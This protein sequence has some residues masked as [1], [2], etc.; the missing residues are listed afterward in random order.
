MKNKIII[1]ATICITLFLTVF[2]VSSILNPKKPEQSKDKD[3]TSQSG[4]T[5]VVKASED[6][7]TPQS[8]TPKSNTNPKSDTKTSPETKT[9]TKPNVVTKK[10]SFAAVGDNLIHSS[11]YE[12]AKL[13]ASGT[14]ETYN[15]LPMYDNVKSMIQS[16][17]L[18]FVNQEG[19]TAGAKLV[20]SGYPLFNA[21]DEA[22]NTLVS[23]GFDI[24]N[25]AN[26]HM[27][28]KGETG[29]ANTIQFW[30]DKPVTTIGGYSSEA[31]YNKIRVIEKSGIKIALLSYTYG[32]NGMVLPTKSPYIIPLINKDE[33]DRQTKEARKLA[34]IVVVSIHWGVEDSF[35]PNDEQIALANLM[36]NN[37]V[38]VILG[39]HPHVL[40]PLEWKTRPDGGKTLVAYSLGNFLSTMLYSRNMVGGVLSFD[41]VKKGDSKATV[42]N[43]AFTPTMTHYNRSNRGLKLY[44]FSEYTEAL[45]KEHGAHKSDPL[46]TMSY[47]T[48]LIHQ[49]IPAEF[50]KESYY[51]TH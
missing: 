24:I 39:Q 11:V 8:E 22:G 43:V 33:V 18:A 1:V 30:K 32:T 38:D 6:A 2:L 20:Y 17:D 36:A 12:D 29:Y 50:L 10:V 46:M 9:P 49:A 7:T 48:N 3:K 40:Q 51:S 41:L 27:L 28:D 26:N 16:V 13:L 45:Q 25:L 42:E 15:F 5:S 4:K 14:N 44:K 35:K 37:G 31:D 19:P 21:P 23:V 34:D 47:M